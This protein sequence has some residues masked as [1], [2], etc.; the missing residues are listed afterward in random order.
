MVR[1]P[2]HKGKNRRKIGKLEERE[3]ERE[4]YAVSKKVEER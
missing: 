2:P 3:A 4:A 1:M